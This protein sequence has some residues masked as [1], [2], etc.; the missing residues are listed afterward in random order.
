MPTRQQSAGPLEGIRVL[1]ITQILSGAF[2]S[3][4]LADMG[5]DVAKI[6]RPGRGDSTRGMGK[7]LPHGEAPSFMAVNRNKRGL[8]LDLASEEGADVLRR[9]ASQA[10]VLV[11]NY[12]P[13]TMAR[14]GL[15]YEDL[16]PLNPSLI[17]C[18]ISG[19]GATGPDASRGGFDLVAQG[20]SG[21]MSFTGE[22][23]GP[24]VKVGVPICD[25]NAGVFG[26]YGILS[27]YI[28]RLRTGE[29]QFVDTSLLEGGI[30]YTVWES[31]TY[32]ALGEVPERRG[33]AHRA[34]APYEVLATQDGYL[35]LG[36]ATEQLWD[37]LCVLLDRP[38]LA[39]DPRFHERGAR[40]AN[41]A[42]LK[43]DLEATFTE[44]TTEEWIELL[45]AAGIP[46]GPLYDIPQVYEDPQV[47]ARDMIVEVE[48]PRAGTNPQ[49]GV[50]VKLSHTP[51]SVRTPAPLLGQHSRIL[52]G[53][54][55][56]DD[57]EIDRL[58]DDGITADPAPFPEPDPE[59]EPSR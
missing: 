26:A 34:I 21:L 23:E 6:E 54:Y 58:M 39:S 4:M 2:C 55:G 57:D 37:K 44:R 32:W 53:E 3:M 30:A 10:D 48:H 27:A 1:D 47:R 40:L 31:S 12:K 18:S 46:S 56:F 49:I 28:H 17:Y 33:S 8:V 22:H 15:S 11:E 19:Y 5:A 29:G 43:V 20:R 59:E 24:P 16:R 52:L 42:E 38:D 45:D 14:F 9:M 35:A 51:G 50:P 41:R 36:C 25:L 7:Q 13:G